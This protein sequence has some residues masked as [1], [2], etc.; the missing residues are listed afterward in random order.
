[1]KTAIRIVS[2]SVSYFV[3]D[4]TGVFGR[5]KNMKRFACPIVNFIVHLLLKSD[6]V[7]FKVEH[8]SSCLFNTVNLSSV[9]CV[10]FLFFVRC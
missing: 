10:L 2:R 4:K 6:A 1:M 3:M 7:M 8:L 5:C 9:A